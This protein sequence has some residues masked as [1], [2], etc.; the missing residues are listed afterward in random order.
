[1]QLT[2]TP[3]GERKILIAGHSHA[4]AL[5][6]PGAKAN[7]EP[8]LVRIEPGFDGLIGPW[9]RS[10]LYWDVLAAEAKVGGHVVALSFLGNEHLAHF[11][12]EVEPFDFVDDLA[13]SALADAFRISHVMNGVS[14][15][16][17][18]NSLKFARK[19]T[20]RPILCSED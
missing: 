5:G 19:K 7:S 3:V 8:A 16:L 15:G 6:L 13:L 14:L 2:E 10:D 18:E 20:A 9:P 1:M 12:I 17:E 11:L 4:Y